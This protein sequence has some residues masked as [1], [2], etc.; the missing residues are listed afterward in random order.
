[1][2]PRHQGGGAD[3]PT[4]ALSCPNCG[5]GRASVEDKRAGPGYIR[6]R[7]KCAGCGGRYTTHEIMASEHET[8]SPATPEQF[9]GGILVHALRQAMAPGR[10]DAALREQV[11]SLTERLDRVERPHGDEPWNVPTEL[12]R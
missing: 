6:R 1:M 10:D 8:G 12:L 9:I 2:S 11:A 4:F 7:R 3:G 5:H